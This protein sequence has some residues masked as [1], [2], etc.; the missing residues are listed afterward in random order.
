MQTIDAECLTM[1]TGKLNRT[2]LGQ[3][4][5]VEDELDEFPGFG[6]VIKAERLPHQ[7]GEDIVP[8]AVEEFVA[9]PEHVVGMEV[10][11]KSPGE[12]ECREQRAGCC[13]SEWKRPARVKSR[14][15]TQGHLQQV[16]QAC[17]DQHA[18]YSGEDPQ[19]NGGGEPE[20][21][22]AQAGEKPEVRKPGLLQQ[23]PRRETEDGGGRWR[24]CR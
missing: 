18:R 13:I 12:D 14:A 19:E 15:V 2:A 22:R 7:A 1:I 4:G 3:P 17:E 20:P 10:E 6:A 16:L 11:E 9:H 8:E 24:V 21:I 23:L 5:L